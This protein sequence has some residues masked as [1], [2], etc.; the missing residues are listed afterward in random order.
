MSTNGVQVA[1]PFEQPRLT[2][3]TLENTS[4]ASAPD[5]VGSG[6]S[7]P[8]LSRENWPDAD[9]TLTINSTCNCGNDLNH[10]GVVVEPRYGLLGSLLFLLGISAPVKEVVYWCEKCGTVMQRSRDAALLK[11][12]RW[13][14]S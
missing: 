2:M 6:K 11:K 5:D 9:E 4:D 8:P 12:Y 14:T 1:R 7:M 10:P 3:S 13:H